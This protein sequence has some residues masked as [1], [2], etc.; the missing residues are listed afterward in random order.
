ML[1]LLGAAITASFFDSLNPSAI[2]EQILLQT[3]VRN[4]RHILFFIAGIGFAN[5]AMGL[6]IYYGAANWASQAYSAITAAYPLYVYGA[7][8][9][10]GLLFLGLGIRLIV[11]TSRSQSS[12]GKEERAAPKPPAQLAPLPLF[13][14]GAAFCFVELTSALPYFGFLALLA[15]YQLIF[16]LVFA[17]ILLY[18]FIYILPL[19]LLYWGYRRLQG[20]K[21][22]QRLESLLSK[23]SLYIVPCAISLFSAVLV[24]HGIN[25]LL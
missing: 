7:E 13:L 18:N 22:I 19:L 1:L 25:A 20:T 4:K 14:M 6:A 23:A 2:S 10:A 8:T 21:A 24:F 15:G 11:K 17:F 5:L 16:P 12:G 3:M 9:A